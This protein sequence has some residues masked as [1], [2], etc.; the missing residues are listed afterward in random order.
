MAYK[1]GK[2]TVA[3]VLK[4]ARDNKGNPIGKRHANPLLNTREYECELE[5]GS[6][7]HNHA[8]VTTENIF[9]QC[10]DEGRQHAV[11]AEIVD[12]KADR[13][14]LRADNG[15]ETTKRGRR[16]TKKT[17]RGWKVLCQWK[18]GLTDWVDMSYVKDSNPIELAKYAVANRIHEEPAFKWCISE[19]LRMRNR[20]I[21]KFKSQY[22]KTSHKYG[23][24]LPHSVQEALQIEKETGLD[25][26]WNAIHKEL[27]KVMVA[28][29]YVGSLTPAQICEGL[30]K[31]KYVGF[32]E[33]K[34]HMIFDAKMDLTRTARFVTCGH[35]TEPPVSITYLSVVSCN[36]VQIAFMLA[37]LN[38]LDILA[39]DIG[40]AY[41]NAPC[42]EKVWCVAGSEFGSRRGT[43]IKIVRAL[44][45]LK[46]S[47]ASWTRTF[48]ADLLRSR[49]GTGTMSIF[50]YMLTTLLLFCKHRK[51]IKK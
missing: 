10:D 25:F 18:D 13:R 22:W 40:N 44:Y 7:L 21:G 12:H 11:L 49:T 46:S 9:A 41:L 48:A 15:Y 28:F 42:R 31:G 34:C 38:D 29:K 14:A 4:R 19:T 51:N 50:L 6:L 35:M 47:G 5:D 23:V 33:I 30:A 24:Q 17:S 3:K 43:V 20:I 36:S 39:C 2:T 32:Q 37:A 16:V 8:N 26:W 45:G 1:D 27:K